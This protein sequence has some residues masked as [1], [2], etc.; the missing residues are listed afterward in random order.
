MYA[1]GLPS[2]A[3]STFGYRAAR[4][5]FHVT[6]MVVQFLEGENTDFWCSGRR[7]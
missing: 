6:H 1:Y 3:S 7:G 2:V 4:V 5:P